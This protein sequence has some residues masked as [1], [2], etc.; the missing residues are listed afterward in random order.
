MILLAFAI[1]FLSFVSS[2]SFS[3]TSVSNARYYSTTSA[4]TSPSGFQYGDLISG[5]NAPE[6]E[7]EFYDLMITILPGGC[8]PM[9]IGRAHV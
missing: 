6:N 2:A 3:S 7:E 5:I 1:M 9:E 8:K 4:Y